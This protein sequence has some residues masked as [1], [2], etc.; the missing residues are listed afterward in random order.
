MEA[1]YYFCAIL[2][3]S[4]GSVLVAIRR[5][6]FFQA[7]GHNKSLEVDAAKSGGAP[8]LCRYAFSSRIKEMFYFP[9][10]QSKLIFRHRSYAISWLCANSCPRM[11]IPAL[12][13][14]KWP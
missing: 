10:I 9:C 11:E 12:G 8:Q 13:K 2:Q 6:V 4:Q 1:P 3:L 14:E 5:M 7:F